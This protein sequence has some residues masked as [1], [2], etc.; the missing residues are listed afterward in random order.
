MVWGPAAGEE[1]SQ[2]RP[3]ASQPAGDRIFLTGGN[4]DAREVYCF[5]GTSGKLLWHRAVTV[6]DS[7]EKR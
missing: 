7:E 3:A 6:P 4:E 2:T 5:D 1:G